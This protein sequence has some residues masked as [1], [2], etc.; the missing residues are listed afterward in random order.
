MARTASPVPVMYRQ[1]QLTLPPSRPPS[2]SLPATLSCLV[3]TQC[4][5]RIMPSLHPPSPPCH[6]LPPSLPRPSFLTYSPTPLSQA[7]FAPDALCA[8]C[9]PHPLQTCLAAHPPPTL[10][11]PSSTTLTFVGK[12]AGSVSPLKTH[13]QVVPA[14]NLRDTGPM[15]AHSS[16][17]PHKES[18]FHSGGANNY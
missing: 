4:V 3:H 16:A 6:A 17:P 15:A 5:M 12:S 9:P 7:Q 13:N 11:H 10:P 1:L 18:C 2:P 14:V 8:P